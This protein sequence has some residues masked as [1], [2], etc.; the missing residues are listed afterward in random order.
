MIITLVNADFSKSNIGVHRILTIASFLGA[1]TVYNGVT[2]VMYGDPFNATI[3]IHE[4]YNIGDAGISITMGGVELSD[5]YSISDNTVTISIASVIGNVVINVPTYKDGE[6]LDIYRTTEPNIC[7]M[8]F[9]GLKF[10]Y[11]GTY[12]AGLNEILALDVS[13]HV[14]RTLRI[15]AANFLTSQANLG[16][17][18]FAIF[19]NGLVKDVN[20]AEVQLEDMATVFN[21]KTSVCNQDA[22][23]VVDSFTVSVE[24]QKANTVDRVVPAGAKYLYV[25]NMR[26]YCETASI[27][28][29]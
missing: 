25:N 10:M 7:L 13:E 9:G 20:G 21:S 3:S 19:T 4:N 2:S 5:A 26:K 6:A 29:L 22:A 23:L 24:S 15:T 16:D 28:L 11:N 27:V 18:H 14:G 17:S 12:G 8:N 1:G